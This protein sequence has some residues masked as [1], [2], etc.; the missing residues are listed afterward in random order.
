MANKQTHWQAHL[1]AWRA[2]GLSQSMYCKK[3]GLSLSSFGYWLHRRTVSQSS[4]T[5]VP[6]VVTKPLSDACL[7]VQLPNGWLVKLPTGME[8]HYVLPLLR[9]LAT[10]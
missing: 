2:S 5:A 7:E 10:C 8:S 9:E 1:D 4:T 3:H 6:I